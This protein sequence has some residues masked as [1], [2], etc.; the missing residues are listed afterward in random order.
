V[1]ECVH[2][3]F[4]QKNMIPKFCNIVFI[5]QFN[6]TM[7]PMLRDVV[8]QERVQTAFP[9]SFHVLLQNEFDLKLFQNG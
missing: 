6:L 7:D 9:H 1:I 4:C 8:G 3:V 2:G 5:K